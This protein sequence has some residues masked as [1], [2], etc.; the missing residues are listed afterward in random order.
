V[1][2]SDDLSMAALSGDHATR[3]A[4]SLAAGCDLVLHCNGKQDEM[5]AVAAGAGPLSADAARRV[6]R[7]EARRLAASQAAEVAGLTA[8]LDTLLGDA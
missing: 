5:A 7:G 2:V 8:R 4:R 3:A 6:A 1:L